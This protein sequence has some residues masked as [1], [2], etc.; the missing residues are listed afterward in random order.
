MDSR[1][2]GAEGQIKIIVQSGID[3]LTIKYY[4]ALRRERITQGITQYGIPT[5][6]H[7]VATY[8]EHN[9][10]GL[11][12]AGIYA[13]APEGDSQDGTVEGIAAQ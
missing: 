3:S 13:I 8:L 6:I 12:T 5:D 1:G 9:V 10:G 7:I 4:V 2:A 11:G